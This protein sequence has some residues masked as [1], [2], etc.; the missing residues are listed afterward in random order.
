MYY[1]GLRYWFYAA[2]LL[3]KCGN[4][5]NFLSWFVSVIFQVFNNREVMFGKVGIQCSFSVSSNSVDFN[6]NSQSLRK[7]CS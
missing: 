1:A 2:S 4:L 3:L 6:G 7:N 5:N